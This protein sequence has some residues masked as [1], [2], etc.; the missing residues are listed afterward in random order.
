MHAALPEAPRLA[1]AWARA[2]AEV[3]EAILMSL[4]VEELVVARMAA[5]VCPAA[6]AERLRACMWAV[7]SSMDFE[8]K[9]P[10]EAAAV[11]VAACDGV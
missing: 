10:A 1:A 3:D 6:V 8:A 7:V 11:A 2:A 9:A 4:E 5:G